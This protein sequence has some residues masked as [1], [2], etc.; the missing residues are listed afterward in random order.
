M[1]R[2]ELLG[3]RFEPGYLQIG[4]SL[5]LRVVYREVANAIAGIPGEERT[6]AVE[7]LRSVTKVLEAAIDRRGF[8]VGELE[9][10]E[11]SGSD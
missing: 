1:N 7:P 9:L 11:E 6:L 3:G 10:C 4:Q 8:V 5:P 2:N